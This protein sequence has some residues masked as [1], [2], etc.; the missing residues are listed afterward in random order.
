MES[1]H[2]ACIALGEAGVLI[3]GPSGA[4]KSTLALLLADSPGGALVADDRV[5]A[6]I[7]D[8]RP[9]MW[10]HPGEAGRI[11]VRGQG[12]FTAAAL[13]LALR[14][15]AVLALVVDLVET[16]PRLPDPPEPAWV[17]GRTIPRLVLDRGV[18]RAG[19]ASLL[20][21]AALRNRGA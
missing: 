15:E 4:G 18:R 14:D 6:E 17:L 16:A 2:A 1:L 12:L 10:A 19:L 21:R 7:R 11:E 3:R 20:V 8:G 13:G 9:V 5:R